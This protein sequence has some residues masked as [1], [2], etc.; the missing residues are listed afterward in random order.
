MHSAHDFLVN[1]SLVFTVAAIVTVT[2]VKLRLPA[3]LGYLLAGMLVGPHVPVPLVADPAVV[4]TLSEL[5]VI[6]LMFCIG[7]EFTLKRFM[8]VAPVGGLIGLAE[9]SL[10]AWLGFQAAGLL[11]WTTPERLFTGAIVA[12]SSTSIIAKAFEEKKVTGPWRDTVLSVLIVE[13]VLAILLMV[14]LGLV[15]G[16]QAVAP[17]RLGW[18]LFRLVASLGTL[19]AAGLL[20]LPR[21]FRL[22]QRLDRPETTV[23]AAVGVCFATSLIAQELGYSVALGAFM[24]GVMVAESGHGEA[25][26]HAIRPV[27]DVFAAL[28]FVAVGMLINPVLVWQNIGAVTLLTFVVVFGKLIG[29]G[30]ASFFAGTGLRGAV[31]VGMTHTQIG[32]FSFIIAGLGKAMGV[33][34]EQLQ[35]VAVAVSVITAF[36]TPIAIGNADRF[37]TWIDHRLPPSLQQLSSVYTAWVE[38]LR[39]A[40]R[41]ERSGWR[42]TLSLL[43]L[44][45]IA[46]IALIVGHSV[47]GPILEAQLVE[48]S[49]ID[50]HVAS[51][52]IMLT[53]LIVAAPLL[54]GVVQL[55]AALG[56]QLVAP[57]TPSEGARAPGLFVALGLLVRVAL[58]GLVGLIV[59]VFTLPFLPP[60]SALFSLGLL[61]GLLVLLL[62]RRT[63]MKG[64][65]LV[66]GARFVAEA[67][68]QGAHS[69]RDQDDTAHGHGHAEPML[70]NEQVRLKPNDHAVGRTLVE[71]DLRARTGAT[72]VALRLPDGKG[73]APQ[74]REAL[75]EGTTLVLVGERAALAAATALLR[76]G[77][78]ETE[79]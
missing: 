46:L 22:V 61:Q 58:L 65:Q 34:G 31:R 52:G 35:P 4:E 79:G 55:S 70:Q 41:T 11:G 9:V 76:A 60:L 77:P 45:T 2:F 21:A 28:F 18:E 40:P 38:Q 6:L 69:G 66:S 44:D 24:G 32:E 23:V 17:E 14:V 26:E 72:V 54:L 29:A 75:G 43:A 64:G 16:G 19:L 27:R 56:E 63:G 15:A 20:V 7:L 47:V 71:L 50:A 51:W 42:R 68:L 78:E 12:I 30:G 5:G 74:G 57:L 62:L 37:A 39:A 73:V 3:V 48:L 59:L 36:T 10:M 13:D 33:V 8:K 53:A 1:L 49:H 25:I 67:L